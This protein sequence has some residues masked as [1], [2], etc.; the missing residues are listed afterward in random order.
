M[1]LSTQDLHS[2]IKVIGLVGSA[3]GASHFFHLVLP[4]LFPIL[5]EEF[6]VTYS[7]L[8]LLTTLFYGVSGI[9]QTLAGFTAG[10]A[11]I[12]RRAMGKKIQSEMDSQ[13]AKFVEGAIKNNIDNELASQIFDQISAFAGYG[14]NKSHAAAYALI[15]NQTAYLTANYPVQFMA[16]LMAL[17]SGNVDKLS[18]FKQDWL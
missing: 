8:A 6:G 7:A 10:E 15:A 18:I 11:D 14:F 4:P 9:A 12:L 16:A 5:K 13:R 1:T 2:D 3:H 17:D